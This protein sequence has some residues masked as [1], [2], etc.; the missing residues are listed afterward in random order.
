[1]ELKAVRIFFNSNKNSIAKGVRP[2]LE[3]AATDHIL[4]GCELDVSSCPKW[5]QHNFRTAVKNDEISYRNAGK[6]MF[7]VEQ[8][9]N[10]LF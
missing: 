2:E 10:Y 8:G 9:Y 6:E 4:T 1:M 7:V 5:L 3:Q